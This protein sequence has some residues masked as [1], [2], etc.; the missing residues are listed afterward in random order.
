MT[1]DRRK[2]RLAKAVRRAA[3]VLISS[4]YRVT[5]LQGEVFNLEAI[6][7]RELRKIRVVID[8][9]SQEDEKKI[10]TLKMPRFCTKEIWCKKIKEPAFEIKEFE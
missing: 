4:N 3:G 1:E 10:R 9:I 5:V 2:K 6:R 7:E 8:V